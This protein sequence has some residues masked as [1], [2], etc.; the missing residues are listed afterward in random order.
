MNTQNTID[1]SGI[2]SELGLAQERVHR[3]IELLDEGNTVPFITRYRKDQ[4]GGLDEQ[5][6]RDVADRV[7]RLRMLADRRATITRAIE[8]QR[9]LTP[10][11]GEAINQAKTVKHLED[12]YLPYKLKKQTLATA[13]RDRGLEPLAR[14][15][16]DADKA[17]NDLDARAADFINEDKG[18]K[19]IADVLLGVGHLLAERFGERADLRGRLR[20]MMWS[21]AKVVSVRIEPPAEE[22]VVQAPRLPEDGEK[23]KPQDPETEGTDVVVQAPRLPEDEEKAKTQGSE[24]EGTPQST[25]AG[26][27]PAPQATEAPAPQPDK[28]KPSKPKKKGPSKQEAAKI[29]RTA[30]RAAARV[31]AKQRK[32]KQLEKA[33]KDYF[34]FTE[35]IDK[36]PPHRI[37]AINRGER[38]RVLRV[39]IEADFDNMRLEA[40]RMVI[41]TNHPH[42]DFLRECL[43]DALTRLIFSSLERELRRELT[44]RAE[45]HAVEVFARNLRKLLLQPPVRGH[46]LLAIDPGFRS[47]CKLAALDEFGN[48]LGHGVIHLV[49]NQERRKRSRSRLVDMLKIHHVTAVAIGNG[50][51][52]RETEQLVASIL[53]DELK[54]EE[55]AYVIVNEAGASVY[56]TSPLGREELP[57][58]DATLR[59]AI[60]IGRRL[61]DPL[62]ELVKIDPASIGVGL[63]QHDVKAKHLRASLDAV[64]ESC[65]NYVGVD[66]N[67]ASPALLRYVSGLNQ[68]T[69]RR[70][71][72]HLRENGPLKNR[73]QLEDV[74][75]IGAATFIQAAGFLKILDGDNPLDATWI[76]PESY[77]TTQAV[78]T[79]LDT[80]VDELAEFVT[81]PKT[82]AAVPEKAAPAAE[83]T[84]EPAKEA[85]AEA[86]AVEPA[87]VE[88]APEPPAATESAPEAEATSPESEASSPEPTA[89]PADSTDTTPVAP[90]DSEITPEPSDS[91]EPTPEP[92]TEP[93]SSETTPESAVESEPTV[94]TEAPAAASETPE[95]ASDTPESPPQDT[96]SETPAPTA[97][98]S[99]IDPSVE[100]QEAENLTERRNAYLNQLTER[101]KAVDVPAVAAELSIG[102]LSLHDM[103]ASLTRPGRDPREDLPAPIL[104]R[105]IV[106]IDDLKPGMELTGSVLNVVDFGVFVDIGLHDSGLVH[107]SRLS[108]TFTADPH[109]VVSVGDIL[110]VWVVEVDKGRRRVSLSAI[111]PG[112]PSAKRAPRKKQGESSEGG[113]R[114]RRGKSKGDDKPRAKGRHPRRDRQSGGRPRTHTPKAKPKPVVPITDDMKKG[115]E[116]MRTFG[117]LKQFFEVRKDDDEPKQDEK[118]K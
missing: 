50:T 39:K 16:F 78:L 44:D 42:S 74:P 17:A 33:F 86:P 6:I 106:K 19:T 30:K 9:K 111:A 67:T 101:A 71:Y 25:E 85:P 118:K 31:A 37:L 26:E 114:R 75:G 56:S 61:L 48:L 76:H 94:E 110:T 97:E 72:D 68:L 102:E 66:V 52:S 116:P 60:S 107:V 51:A 5:Q 2:S 1:L 7:G 11:L 53:A 8:S 117:D 87:A 108:S 100:Q 35:A 22:V 49:G 23:A 15:V 95:T 99:V 41:L 34:A 89:S 55:L 82:K 90:V 43:N 63:Y 103:I 57:K 92:T 77:E 38:A 96:P 3:T 81:P 47:G 14:E 59:G 104:R 20:E 91:T 45:T 80:S 109:D 36:L 64:V 29:A 112:A 79:K 115:D 88:K 83:A 98:A 10:E 21:S 28:P 84:A 105:G 46:R 58:C 40:E 65:V 27:A 4:T 93:V 73:K 113:P 12:L 54:D 18:V 13:A 32:K 62:S 24:T 69:A 70:L